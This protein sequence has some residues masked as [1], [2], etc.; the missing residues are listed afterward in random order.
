MEDSLHKNTPTSPSFELPLKIRLRSLVKLESESFFIATAALGITLQAPF[1][2]LLF[3]PDDR[4]KQK[5]S[6]S[7][8]GGSLRMCTTYPCYSALLFPWMGSLAKAQQL[9]VSP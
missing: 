1:Q 7:K 2:P 6:Q 5:G 9:Q 8:S 4:S 3:Y